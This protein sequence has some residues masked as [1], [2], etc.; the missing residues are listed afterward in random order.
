MSEKWNR[1]VRKIKQVGSDKLP[2]LI[3][4]LIRATNVK[5]ITN[6][7]VK[8]VVTGDAGFV[9]HTNKD[10][11]ECKSLILAPGRYDVSWM[12]GI[13]KKLGIPYKYQPI[14]VGV[15][16]EFP[17]QITEEYAKLLYEPVFM[18][19]TKTFDDLV[20]TFCP[21]PKGYVTKEGYERRI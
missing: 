1:T 16:V 5:I 14:E 18:I 8:D 10:R 15:R 4:R 9:L 12:Q 3:K 11:I 7:D 6:T 17:Y 19:R 2:E 20:R 21:C 13:V